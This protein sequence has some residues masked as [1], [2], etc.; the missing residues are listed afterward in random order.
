MIHE[1]IKQVHCYA[2]NLPV[3]KIKKIV[4]GTR[5]HCKLRCDQKHLIHDWKCQPLFGKQRA[6]RG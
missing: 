3:E 4:M 6:H 5:L 2:Y 1:L